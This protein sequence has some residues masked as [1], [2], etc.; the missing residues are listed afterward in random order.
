MTTFLQFV[1]SH[2]KAEWSNAAMA[3]TPEIRA[4]VFRELVG[5]GLVDD[6]GPTAK[7]RRL[8]AVSQAALRAY[9]AADGMAASPRAVPA[10]GGASGVAR[11][12]D[13]ATWTAARRAAFEAA[14]LSCRSPLGE[15]MART[16]SAS[17]PAKWANCRIFG[18]TAKGP[19]DLRVP[20]AE[21]RPGGALPEG[22]LVVAD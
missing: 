8:A 19:R 6:A 7:G 21:Y 9:D 16:V 10:A 20:R 4:A 5:L 1:C 2:P 18:G 11:V 15:F 22:A 17:V 13:F 14:G 3:M 12:T